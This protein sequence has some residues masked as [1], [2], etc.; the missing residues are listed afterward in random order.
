MV[1]WWSVARRAIGSAAAGHWWAAAIAGSCRSPARWSRVEVKCSGG[2]GFCCWNAVERRVCTCTLPCGC[3]RDEGKS[4]C[5]CC[6][7]SAAECW[8]SQGGFFLRCCICT[9]V[10]LVKSF[11]P[12]ASRM[13][14]LPSGAPGLRRQLLSPPGEGTA[15]TAGGGSVRPSWTPG[16]V[17]PMPDGAP[18]HQIMVPARVRTP[19]GPQDGR[20]RD[21]HH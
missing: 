5:S 12:A 11:R 2:A 14:S 9:S 4:C 17:L 18:E 21:A 15:R 6:C 19:R 20:R 8:S 7:R 16:P 13:I 3:E 1:C 10:V